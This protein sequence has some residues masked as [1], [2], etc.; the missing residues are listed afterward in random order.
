MF[1][2]EAY[3]GK[4]WEKRARGEALQPDEELPEND[5]M[6]CVY[7]DSDVDVTKDLGPDFWNQ[8]QVKPLNTSYSVTADSWPEINIH[9]SG[10]VVNYPPIKIEKKELLERSKNYFV[11]YKSFI[12]QKFSN[13]NY[14]KLTV[15]HVDPGQGKK[16]IENLYIQDN[17]CDTAGAVTGLYDLPVGTTRN[18]VPKSHIADDP[19]NPTLNSGS[20]GERV[21]RSHERCGYKSWLDDLV[22]VAVKINGEHWGDTSSTLKY[23]LMSDDAQF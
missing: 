18:L 23:T 20:T 2:L 5:Q 1:D 10:L 4:G 9:G 14:W 11:C 19:N 3:D 8:T 21:A 6:V 13:F 12:L 22:V 16:H 17:P 15:E 7:G